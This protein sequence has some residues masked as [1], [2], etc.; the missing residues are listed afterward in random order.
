L[1]PEGA[2]PRTR[3][4]R[5]GRR[6]ALAGACS[7][8][9]LISAFI[10]GFVGFASSLER[11]E[12]IL[13]VQAEGVVALTGGS[14]RVL[15][16]AEFL[17]RGQAR[18]LLIT[19]VNRAT[20]GADLEKILP[21][22]RDLFACCVDLGY[23]AMDT[24]GNARET[25]EWARARN[26][27]GPLIVVTSNYHMPRAM[28]ELSA[29]LPGFTLYPFPVVSEHV[30]VRSWPGDSRVRGLIAREYLKYLRAIVRTKWEGF[31]GGRDAREGGLEKP[32]F[33]F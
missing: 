9:F 6:L 8:A 1:S 25:L 17:A 15:E 10:A 7:G 28:V 12:P 13:L 19:G 30:N 18:R 26:I 32:R 2:I 16:A 20:H 29:A 31:A 24:A 27:R 23:K 3:K 21:V 4:P 22:S 5:C 11:T 33:L 14:D